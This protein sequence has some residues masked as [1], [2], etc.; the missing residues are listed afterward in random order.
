QF[1][2]S[3]F[4]GPWLVDIVAALVSMA[5]LAL[6]LRVWSPERP[7]TSTVP[8][9]DEH[10]SAVP[11]AGGPVD[12]PAA[13]RRAW[14]PWIVLSLFVF[15]WGVPQVRAAL[16]GIWAAKLPVLGLHEQVQKV[17]PVVTEAHTEAAIY[18]LNL[19]SAT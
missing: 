15:L 10:A 14:T 5:S 6:F 19:L 17:P 8:G 2:V 1:L 13:V 12:S 11:P 3:N 18:S 16:D 4:H 9:D 7:M